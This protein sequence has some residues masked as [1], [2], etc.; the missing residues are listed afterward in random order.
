MERLLKLAT[1]AA[2]Q[3]E[4]FYSNDSSD[5]LSFTDSK[6]EKADTSISSGIALRV[7]KDGKIG[8]AHTRNLLDREAL[9]KQALLSAKDGMEVGFSFPLTTNLPKLNTYNPAIEN[10]SKKDLVEEGKRML[11]YIKEKTGGQ[12]N[13]GFGYSISEGGIMNSAGTCLS[14][15][16][17][18]Y[19]VYAMLV[20]PG[21]G[22]GLFKVSSSNGYKTLNKEELDEMIELFL[23][24]RTEVVPE[25]KKMPVIFAESSHF[26]LLSRFFAAA[27]PANFYNKVSP[28]LNRIGEQIVSPKL[29]LWQDPFDPEFVSSTAFDTE[30]SP[31]QKLS[32]IDK[33]IFRAI[34]TDLNYAN[35]L[36]LAPTGNGLRNSIEASPSPQAFNIC[37]GTGD[38]SLKEMIASIDKG[39]I[40]QSLMGAHSG[41]ILN[42]EYSVGVSSGFY[43]ENGVIT[44]RVKDCMIS[45]NAYETLMNVSEIENKCN[46]SSSNKLPSILCDGVSVAGK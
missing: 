18:Y 35:K 10:L 3:A 43:I 20:F 16:D 5:D 15:K 11:T 41:N 27:S 14:Q 17:S 8:L 19:W 40:V 12:V 7:I 33:G 4:V 24:S 28:L 23:L 1:Q 26:A 31:T 34:P 44:G 36:G 25:T 42:G 37:M 32:F 38:K 9:V 21:T 22:S 46:K 2:D 30:G 45:G 29:N 39:I 13:A 6:L